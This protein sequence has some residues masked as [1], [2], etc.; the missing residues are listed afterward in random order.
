M[1]VRIGSKQGTKV[2]GSIF[3]TFRILKECALTGIIQYIQ[4]ARERLVDGTLERLSI[5][6][7]NT[8]N[9]LLGINHLAA[10][11]VFDFDYLSISTVDRSLTHS[12][13]KRDEVSCL[14]LS[15]DIL[16]DTKAMG[17]HCLSIDGEDVAIFGSE[18]RLNFARPDGLHHCQKVILIGLRNIRIVGDCR[19]LDLCRDAGTNYISVFI[20]IHLHT[21]L[22]LRDSIEAVLNGTDESIRLNPDLLRGHNAAVLIENPVEAVTL[23]EV[24]ALLDRNHRIVQV[25]RTNQVRT[26]ATCLDYKFIVE[27]IQNGRTD[28]FVVLVKEVSAQSSISGLNE[29]HTG[30]LKL[31]NNVGCVLSSERPIDRIEHI[32]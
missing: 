16:S 8:D 32:L 10:D 23:D 20:R 27:G 28:D 17:C 5:E 13:G 25:N 22:V 21:T 9:T 29:T 1:E 24:D 3:F 4:A 30:S 12:E 11:R 14:S 19:N 26:L 7:T 6:T 31:G 18:Y 2:C 15:C